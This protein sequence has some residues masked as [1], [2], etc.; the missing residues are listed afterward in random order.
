MRCLAGACQ[1]YCIFG[2]SGGNY[3]LASF[4]LP[5][6]VLLPLDSLKTVLAIISLLYP[7]FNALTVYEAFVPMAS[8]ASIMS[9]S[10]SSKFDCP[11]VPSS[12]SQISTIVL[13]DRS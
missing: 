2:F 11:S 3:V 12:L 13:R 5:I 1:V 8:T 6:L 9:S 7:S 10:S 4:F